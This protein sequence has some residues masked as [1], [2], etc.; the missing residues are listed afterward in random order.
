V[1]VDGGIRVAGGMAEPA[2]ALPGLKLEV[3]VAAFLGEFE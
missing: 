3:A 2:Q 1:V